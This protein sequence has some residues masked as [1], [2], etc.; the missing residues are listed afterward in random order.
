[1]DSGFVRTTTLFCQ[2]RSLTRLEALTKMKDVPRDVERWLHQHKLQ[3]MLRVHQAL[4]FDDLSTALAC[5]EID[6]FSEWIRVTL[7]L[8]NTGSLAEEAPETE[9]LAE[10]FGP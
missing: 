9:T 6:I 5:P 10:Y 3:G 1:M 7:D 8:P 4:P 2:T